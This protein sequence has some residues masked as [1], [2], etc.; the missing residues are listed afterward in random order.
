MES[1]LD[2]ILFDGDLRIVLEYCGAK[3][4]ISK[5]ERKYAVFRF[6]HPK[7][8]LLLAK[9]RHALV[10]LEETSLQVFLADFLETRRQMHKQFQP[11]AIDWNR[12]VDYLL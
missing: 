4:A 11:E 10:L 12:I 8:D 2:F 3:N 7:E 5:I 6:G 1:L 9:S